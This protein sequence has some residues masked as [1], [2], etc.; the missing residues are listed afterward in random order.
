MKVISIWVQSI[1][2]KIA[3]HM[4]DT[5]EWVSQE[6]QQHYKSATQQAG[7]IVMG[8]STFEQIGKPLPKRLNI[9][10]TSQPELFEEKAIPELLEFS[11]ATPEQLL[12]TLDERGFDTVFISGGSTIYSQFTEQNLI[13]EWW[14]TIEPYLFG[15]GIPAV[16]FQ[17]SIP[18]TLLNHQ[19][20]N[21]D[22]ILL[23]YG[24][25]R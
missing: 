21:H 17:E 25:A 11:N 7:V 22:T 9:V 8:K 23:K 13:D 18:L 15:H 19:T 14:I 4:D 10:M 16:K 20:L 6:D 24:R 3:T 12:K 2:G 1:D 5:F